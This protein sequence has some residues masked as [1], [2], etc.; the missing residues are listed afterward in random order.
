MDDYV[1]VEAYDVML[2]ASYDAGG[3]GNEEPG[4][5]QAT[6][7]SAT[8][9]WDLATGI[10]GQGWVLEGVDWSTHTFYNIDFYGTTDDEVRQKLIPFLG[11]YGGGQIAEMGCA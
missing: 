11:Q 8:A 2:G 10:T 3:S 6:F 9:S 4:H 1:A 7:G 5:A